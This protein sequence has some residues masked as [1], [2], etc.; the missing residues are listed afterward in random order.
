MLFFLKSRLYAPFRTERMRSNN[1]SDFN[2]LKGKEKYMAK[3][4][5]L[6]PSNHG[7]NQNRCLKADCFEDKHTRPIAEV[8]ARYLKN[9]G[10]EVVVGKPSQNMAARCQEADKKGAELYVP[11]HTNAAAE[12]ARYL[13]FMFYNDNEVY[14]KLFNAV[15]PYLEKVYPGNK[16]A[17]F[18]KRATLYEINRPKAKTM[19]CELGFHTNDTDVKNFI[20]DPEKVGKALAQGICNYFGVSFE[21][22]SGENSS[23]QKA[24]AGKE[25]RLKETPLYVSSAAK[26]PSA[27]INGN[28]YLWD[29][30]FIRGRIR[31]TNSKSRVGVKNQITG[32]I[33][34]KDI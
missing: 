17:V 19:Y 13:L 25:I 34:K 20:H 7:K 18:Q 10:F 32:W 26:A 3:L 30:K 11:V 9:S 33:D 5:Y 31:I 12:T 14:R 27:H 6:S 24:E 1:R 29:N 28:Y 8:C 15:S 4:I 21:G 23:L 16:K 2:I 22:A